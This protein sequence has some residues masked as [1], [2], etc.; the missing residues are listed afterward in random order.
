MEH[1]AAT[2]DH[3]IQHLSSTPLAMVFNLCAYYLPGSVLA[4]PLELQVF[5]SSM[6][7][8]FR[9]TLFPTLQLEQR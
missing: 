9:L 5:K 4:I 8:K 3:H 7:G 1:L 2:R 6:R